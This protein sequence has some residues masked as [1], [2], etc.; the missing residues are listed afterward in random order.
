MSYDVAVFEP[1]AF[2]RD[3]EA[4]RDWFEVRTQW[5]ER[6]NDPTHATP[7][8]QASFEEISKIFPPMNGPNTPLEEAEA[9][10][11]TVDYVFA[12][13][14]IYVAISGGRAVVGYEVVSLA[15]RRLR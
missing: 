13:D 9:W 4:F 2:L 14:M 7:R 6:G 15:P 12:E 10:E 5:D 1:E 8:L 11:R 3:R